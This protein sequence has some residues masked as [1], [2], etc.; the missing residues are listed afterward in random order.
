MCRFQRPRSRHGPSSAKQPCLNDSEPSGTSSV[1]IETVQL[2]QSV[3]VGAHA[4][5][6]VEAEQL[7]AGRLETQPAVRAGIVSRKLNIAARCRARRTSV[8][9]AAGPRAPLAAPGRF[10][11]GGFILRL[12]VGSGRI[13]HG[14][15]DQAAL[16]QLQGQLHSFCQPRPGVAGHE[17][18]DHH[19]DVVPHLAV[20]V[21][22]VGERH[23]P[24]V[25]AGPG[26]ALLEQIDEQVAILALLSPNE[27]REHDELRAGRQP[28]DLLDDLFAGLS[29]DR[30]RTLG[31][32]PLAGAGIQHTQIVVD[33]GDR[34]DRGARVLAG[35]FLR[36][37]DRR[38]QP[39]DVIH[40]GLGHLAQKLPGEARQTFDIRAV[41][42]RHT[43]CRR[44]ASSFPIHSPRSGKSA[45]CGEA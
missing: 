36:D 22:L 5:R 9:I 24:P 11:F 37:R 30:S 42:P 10:H 27:R 2:A 35:R 12:A 45:G 25:H 20:E 14:R 17:A 31:A 15:N 39:A 29:G 4:L 7:R 33:L 8:G 28:V 43:A 26:K 23:D 38:A 41:A 34:A 18:I 13:G 3:A 32:M 6:T 44:P 16:P 19:L 40:V 21:L 1:G